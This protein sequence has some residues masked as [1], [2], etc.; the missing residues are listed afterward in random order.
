VNETE[1]LS[2]SDSDF[3]GIWYPTFTYSVSQMFIDATSYIM[4]ANLTSTTLTIAISETSYYVQNVQSP[5][6]KQPEVIFHTLLFTIVCLE[7]C[8][9]LFVIC[10]LVVIPLFYKVYALYTGHPRN[11]V[12][13]EHELKSE[14]E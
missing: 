1:P 5:I 3:A 9:L 10:K 14:H 7:L 4:S 11:K 8:G 6:A 13:T 12:Y 2:G